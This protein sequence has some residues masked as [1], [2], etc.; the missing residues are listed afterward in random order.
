MCEVFFLVVA[1]E[2]FPFCLPILH[3]GCLI[4][5]VE[6]ATRLVKSQQTA[7]KEYV[8]V[9]RCHDAVEQQSLQQVRSIPSRSLVSFSFSFERRLANS[10]VLSSSGHHSFP[11]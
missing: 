8:C 1:V 11:L 4:V 5:C 3:A 6:R 9:L 2:S 10:P 7:G